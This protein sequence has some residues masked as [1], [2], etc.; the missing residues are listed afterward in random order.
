EFEIQLVPERCLWQLNQSDI[1]NLLRKNAISMP[2][3]KKSSQK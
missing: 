2:T 3:D 1:H